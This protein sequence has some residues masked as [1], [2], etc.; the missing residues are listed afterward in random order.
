MNTDSDEVD[1]DLIAALVRYVTTGD[2]GRPLIDGALLVFLPGWDDISR[3]K[4]TL[5]Q[6]GGDALWVLPLHS[7]VPPAEQK[8]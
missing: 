3:L 6:A 1:L 5:E 7:M 8:K 2:G 4:D